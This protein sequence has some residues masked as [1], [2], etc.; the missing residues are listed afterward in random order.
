MQQLHLQT[1]AWRSCACVR[2]PVRVRRKTFWRRPRQAG[3]ETGAHCAQPKYCALPMCLAESRSRG[4][5]RSFRRLCKNALWVLQRIE[6]AT[7]CACWISLAPEKCAQR[8]FYRASR[9]F[10]PA[11]HTNCIL[12][13]QFE[14]SP[15]EREGGGSERAR[16]CMRIPRYFFSRM[17]SSPEQLVMTPVSCWL[18]GVM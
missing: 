8:A 11:A 5:S 16:T 17:P 2:W 9:A 12:E 14:F 1:A 7:P 4:C 18:L 6:R 10:A 13:S 3:R 15:S